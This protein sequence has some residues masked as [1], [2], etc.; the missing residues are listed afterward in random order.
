MGRVFSLPGLKLAQITRAWLARP[1]LGVTLCALA[2]QACGGD[3]PAESV[4]FRSVLEEYEGGLLLSVTEVDGSAWAVGGIPGKTAILRTKDGGLEPVDNPGESA[5]WWVCDLNDGVAVVGEEGLILTYQGGDF[6]RVDIGIESILYGCAGDSVDDF[7]VVG[8]DA[9][10]GIPEMARVRD[11][12][13][14]APDLGALVEQLPGVLFKIQIIEQ[15]LFVVGEDGVILT[16][17]G[18]D[19]WSLEVLGREPLFTVSGTAADDVWA[20]GGR[21]EGV[22]YHFDGDAWSEDFVGGAPG[23][24]GVAT[25]RDRVLAVGHRGAMFERLDEGWQP[26]PVATEEV[27]HAAWIGEDGHAWAVGGNVLE[28][29]PSKRRGVVLM[30]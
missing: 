1:C 2:S 4:E 11:G 6:E 15:R 27:L 14:R 24:F 3:D 16:G 28:Q 18:E 29:S 12:Q 30:R 25:A 7:W 17:D 8:G 20:V 19:D 5:A 10:S 26:L 21:S 22:A 13:G 9:R 23:L